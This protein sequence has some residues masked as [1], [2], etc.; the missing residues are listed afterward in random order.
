[1]AAAALNVRFVDT[2]DNGL[3]ASDRETSFKIDLAGMKFK[4]A[5]KFYSFAFIPA[6]FRL[7][8]L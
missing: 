3:Q 8:F 5:V 2:F 4:Q 7:T 1:M 6:K